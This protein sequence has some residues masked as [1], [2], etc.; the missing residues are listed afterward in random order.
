MHSATETPRALHRQGRPL[1]GGLRMGSALKAY[2]YFELEE[3]TSSLEACLGSTAY[4]D[5]G[6]SRLIAVSSRKRAGANESA[7]KC[8]CAKSR[9]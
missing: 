5:R 9:A 6:F 7:S 4:S 2:I 1:N 3:P 8:L